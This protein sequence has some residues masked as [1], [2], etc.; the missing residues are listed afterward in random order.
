MSGDK[1]IQVHHVTRVEGHGN[2]NVK[3]RDGNV[4]EC[5]WQVVEAPRF[6]EAM[7]RG[8]KWNEVAH[9]TSRICGICSIGHTLASLKATEAAMGITVSDQT[10]K[11]RKILLHAENMQSHILH[12]GYLVLPDLLRQPS[13]VPLAA[14]HRDQV[15]LVVRLHRL[16]NEMSDLLGGRTTHPQRP[17]VGGFTK[18]PTPK[19]LE[20][21]RERLE[22]G[23]KD[24]EDLAALVKTLAGNLPSFQRETEFIG[25]THGNE[26]ALYEGDIGSTDGGTWPVD[27]YKGIVNEY[28]VPQS[29][30]KFSRHNR[31]AYM[32][33]AL[34]RL[35]LNYDLLTPK[36]KA[37][38]ESFGLKPVNHNPYMNNVAQIVEV[39]HNI[40]DSIR[41]IDDLLKT[42]IDDE[43]PS[44]FYKA[45]RG[46]SGVEV[47]RGI[48]F[49]EYEYN[50]DG[51][52]VWANCVIP[53]N[54]NH[55][56]IQKDFEALVPQIKD[57]PREEIELLLEMLVRAY[58]PCI[59]CSTHCI[60]L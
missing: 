58:D 7:L 25:L 22:G 30:A 15:L 5:Q 39:V 38:A 46:S 10:L 35:N 43:K 31:E 44:V 37:V 47:P 26:Y 45:G 60:F 53:T 36:A 57:Q 11:V 3:I 17:V 9:I 59:S 8:R 20:T 16:A 24:A 41:M 32:V 51:E 42:G 1:I 6:F 27:Q 34:A 55:A 52:C 56:N 49:H 40:E 28:C 29:T 50:K 48:L 13:V 54:Q 2:I 33:G 14:S 23:L 18:W 12:V 21:L 19:E 4:E